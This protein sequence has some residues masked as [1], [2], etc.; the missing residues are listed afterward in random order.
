MALTIARRQGTG[1][2]PSCIAPLRRVPCERRLAVS[3]PSRRFN[4]SERKVFANIEPVSLRA[5]NRRMA[6]L[7]HYCELQKNNPR[8]AVLDEISELNVIRDELRRIQQR[9]VSYTHLRAHETPEH[10][11]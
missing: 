7:L 1:R 3:V 9:A 8:K 11:V 10:L 5:L 4:L 2:L 6:E